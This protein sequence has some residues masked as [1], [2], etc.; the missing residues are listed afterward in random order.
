MG[1][2]AD[3]AEVTAAEHVLA[4]G[5]T[6]AAQLVWMNRAGETV[7]P[8]NTPVELHNPVFSADGRYVAAASTEG[9][10]RGVW[11]IDVSSGA[12]TR[13]IAGA[14]GPAWSPDGT[15][16]GYYRETEGVADLFA[17]PI[18]SA[19]A[20]QVML[21][22]RESKTLTDWSR[23]GT[24]YVTSNPQSKFDL[25]LL[26]PGGSPQ[27]LVQTPF[28]EMQG[29]WSPDG[30]WLAYASDES[31]DW[32]VYVQ[33]ADDPPVRRA[34]SPGGGA[35]P[36]WR[37]DGRELFYISADRMLMSMAVTPGETW[38][39]SRPEPLFR[40]PVARGLTSRRNFFAVTPDGERF[41]F[42]ADGTRNPIS[43]LVNWQA[44]LAD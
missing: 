13:I 38:T 26:P 23:R 15:Q 30:R 41:L 20:A 32:G 28:N 24:V 17:S 19:D 14:N 6:T 22:T 37:A 2:V 4:F 3:G 7:E 18:D 11:L 33:S 39:G 10:L 8:L 44:L 27:P 35:A 21:R 29:Q 9:D 43:V 16:L 1:N 42:D 12:A 25:W 5:G 40:V 34:V 36:R 31:G